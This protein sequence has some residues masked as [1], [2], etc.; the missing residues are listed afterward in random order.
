MKVILL[1]DTNVGKSSFFLRFKENRFA[2]KINSTIGLDQTTKDISLSDGRTVKI[3]LWDTAGLESSLTNNFFRMSKGVILIYDLEECDTLTTLRNRIQ[4]VLSYNE[5]TTFFLLGNKNDCCRAEVAKQDAIN[6][7]IN[8]NIPVEHV[9]EISVKTGK[10]FDDFISFV[11]KV[12]SNDKNSVDPVTHSFKLDNN[13][14][15]L[16]GCC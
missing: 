2:E 1:G 16:F 10:G 3:N 4:E 5:H 12:L 8:N 9:F 6:F 14:R 11:A 15:K 7:A 13:K